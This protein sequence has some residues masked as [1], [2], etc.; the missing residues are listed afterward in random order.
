MRPSYAVRSA[1]DPVNVVDQIQEDTVEALL[2]SVRH[3]LDAEDTR[4]QSFMARASGLA[5]FAGLIVSVSGIVGRELFRHEWG[6]GFSESLATTSFVIGVASLFATLASAVFGVLWP[7]AFD[8]ISMDEIR[9]YPLREMIYQPKVVVQ[10]RTLRGPVEALASERDRNSRKASW[11]KW[12]Y[13]FL[14]VAL[15]LVALAALTLGVDEA[16]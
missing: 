10:G 2:D 14:V 6:S 12:A 9:R 5:G 7:R 3:F 16:S 11:L 4:S 15:A 1:V 13:G 8:T